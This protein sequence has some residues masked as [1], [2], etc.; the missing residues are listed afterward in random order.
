[1][2]L[3]QV[4]RSIWGVVPEA[5]RYKKNLRPEL[6]RGSAVAVAPDT[7]LAS[8]RVVGQREQVGVVRHNKY[9]LAQ[10][11][12]TRKNRD[13]CSL[14][15]SNTPLNVAGGFRSFE[16]LREGEP[17]YA[18]VSRTSAEYALAEGQLAAKRGWDDQLLETTVL[19]PPQILSAPL[20]DARGNLVGLGSG[21][22]TGDSLVLGAPLSAALAPRL[23]QR[24]LGSP[25]VR[26]AWL[27]IGRPKQ[28]LLVFRD[29][30]DRDDDGPTLIEPVALE[31]IEER[32]GDGDGDDDDGGRGG[33][34][35]GDDDDGGRGGGGDGD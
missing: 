3:K 7:L 24:D 33:G 2:L 26:V 27:P 12:R 8:C 23:A 35:D 30:Q 29:E 28:S 17:V 13:V 6:I 5:P 1:V 32:P 4:A 25:D 19:L 18:V 14:Q 22:P 31:P 21:G 20:F 10:V 34:G 11:L 15:V 16:D 9:R